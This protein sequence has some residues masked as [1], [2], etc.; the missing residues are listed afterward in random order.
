MK[1]LFLGDVVGISGRSKILNN[2]LSEI[3]KKN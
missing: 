2:L 3:K 1:I